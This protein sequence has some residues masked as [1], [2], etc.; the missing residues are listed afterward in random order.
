MEVTKQND[1]FELQSL[2]DLNKDLMIAKQKQEVNI[3]LLETQKSLYDQ[4]I[5]NSEK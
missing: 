5:K 4:D 1:D 3:Q 2:V